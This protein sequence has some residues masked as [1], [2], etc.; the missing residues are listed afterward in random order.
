M[1]TTQ[2]TAKIHA[3]EFERARANAKDDFSIGKVAPEGTIRR[4]LTAQKSKWNIPQE[5]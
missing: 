2:I 1:K 3:E 5:N 4:V